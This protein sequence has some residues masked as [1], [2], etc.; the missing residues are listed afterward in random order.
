MGAWLAH[1]QA[2]YRS[3]YR[4]AIEQTGLDYQTLR[5]YAWVAGRFELSRRRD[6]LS[7][8]RHAEAAALAGRSRRIRPCPRRVGR[9]IPGGGD[10]RR[11]RILQIDG[12]HRPLLMRMG[13]A[14]LE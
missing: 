4:T 10:G 1:G 14:P 12:A 13:A 11:P 9:D 7:F 2:A 6:T 3:R 8:G 5:N